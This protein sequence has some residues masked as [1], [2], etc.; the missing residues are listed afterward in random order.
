MVVKMRGKKKFAI[1]AVLLLI[2][3][4]GFAGC[5]GGSD[6][7]ADGSAGDEPS[8]GASE[9][10][11][12]DAGES[13]GAEAGDGLAPIAKENIKAAFIYGSAVG[14][15][16]YSYA[17]DLGRE[18]LANEGYEVTYVEGIP[19]TEQFEKTVRDLI[20]EGYNVIYAT[21]FG[22]GPYVEKLADEFPNIYF[23][24]ATGT[25]TKT[26]LSTYMGRL[27]QS[28]Y[29]AGIAAG[30]KTESGQIGY[31]ASFP[32]PEVV[33]QINAFTLGA[34]SVNPSATV[35][36]KWTNS[37]YD[38][39]TEK[40]AGLELVNTGSDIVIAYLD[41][42]SAQIAAAEKG[43]WAI[44]CS[45]SG[46]KV[47]PDVYLTAPIFNWANFY[48]KNVQDIVDGTWKPDF[49]FLGL[50]TGVVDIDPLTGNNADGAAEKVAAA[51]EAIIAG[52]LNVFGGEIKDNEGNAKV[53]ADGALTDEEIL[54]INWFVEGVNGKIEAVSE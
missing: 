24:H 20:N 46:A 49:Q 3:V 14:E 4:M 33:S 54:T 52:E 18:A 2:L 30:L 11:S 26:N 31:V 28:Q 19:E 7:G 17:H 42:M 41:T 21:S 5:S 15:E 16:G 39:V 29:L 1:L 32:L 50:E 48:T 13:T 23:N 51:K 6:A 38:P 25:V 44:G 22:Y 10:A 9:E 8:A 40:S 35:N 43:A 53:P 45:T 36:V 12:A 47:L 37:W 34:R 27:Y